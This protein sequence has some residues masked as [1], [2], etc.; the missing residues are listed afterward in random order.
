MPLTCLWINQIWQASLL[1]TFSYNLPG[2]VPIDTEDE[3]LTFS[4]DWPAT[5]NVI[6]EHPYGIV[7]DGQRS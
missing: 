2:S 6:P 1:S 3:H 5:P 7:I 4:C